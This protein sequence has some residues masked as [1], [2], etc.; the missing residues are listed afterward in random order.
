MGRDDSR[1]YNDYSE[2]RLTQELSVDAIRGDLIDSSTNF[3]PATEV[4]STLHMERP[5]PLRQVSTAQH[6]EHGIEINKQHNMRSN[7]KV[8]PVIEKDLEWVHITPSGW[9]PEKKRSK[10]KK[11]PHRR[12]Q[13]SIESREKARRMRVIRACLKCRRS[14][15][16]VFCNFQQPQPRVLILIFIIVFRRT[17]V[18]KVLEVWV[19]YWSVNMYKRAPL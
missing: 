17:G 18:Y 14:K 7:E 6:R 15:V 10:D 3:V 1:S 8:L 2:L 9:V 19:S 4:I 5:A 13:L 12:S 16:P 11:R